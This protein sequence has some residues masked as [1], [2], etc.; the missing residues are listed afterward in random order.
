MR[1]T[2]HFLMVLIVFTGLLEATEPL[3]PCKLFGLVYGID[4]LA[5]MLIL[6][7]PDGYLRDVTL[8]SGTVISKLPVAGRGPITQIRAADLNSGDLVCVHGGEG[9]TPPQLSV[10]LRTD[11][12]RAQD[13]FLVEWQRNSVFGILSSIDV[14]GRTF[15]VNPLPRSANDGPIRVSLP[16]SVQLR[17]VPP[18]AR[19]IQEST[20]F[21][22][23]D[24]R[25]G[26]AVYVRGA[27]PGDGAN[28]TA[29]LVL[30]G[31]YR[32][33]LG[34]L[35]EVRV[36]SSVLRIREFGTGRLLDMKVASGEVYRTTENI[37]HPMRV[38]TASGVVLAPVGL[39]DL[40]T[41][42]AIL[43]VGK[44][45]DGASEGEGVVAVTKFGTFG[46]APHDPQD[47]ISWLIA[48]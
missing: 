47:R 16:G 36:M 30:H 9:D 46:V 2:P 43:I 20:S 28:M 11:L 40:Q 48:K 18:G 42:D 22:L 5:E 35:A 27:R 14:K 7:D 45:A 39:A 21:R 23:E 31:G 13:N 15:V 41:G 1:R 24:L 37:T 10:V 6:K 34:T 4:P 17:A 3:G 26:E 29:S 12:H 44:I 38:E 19:R 33:I 25:P 8:A 32:G